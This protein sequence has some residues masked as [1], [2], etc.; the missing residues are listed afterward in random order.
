[1]KKLFP[2]FYFLLISSFCVFAQNPT[3]APPINPSLISVTTN[4]TIYKLGEEVKVTVTSR[5]NEVVRVDSYSALGCFI[6]KFIT[7]KN[8]WSVVPM[9][10]C[11]CENDV[12][13]NM[14]ELDIEAGAPYVFSWTQQTSWCDGGKWKG[15]VA[16]PG[17]Y[18]VQCPFS[19]MAG[20]VS[21]RYVV[22]SKEFLIRE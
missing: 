20:G 10:S 7:E 13:C 22:T 14:P 16:K 9:V 5:A 6:E 3:P 1:M 12:A 19:M 17:R 18:Q 2:I 21:Q 4:K 15:D 8:V 11:T